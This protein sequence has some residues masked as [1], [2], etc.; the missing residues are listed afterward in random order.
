MDECYTSILL[1]TSLSLSGHCIFWKLSK[2]Q[3]FP[4]PARAVRVALF[5]PSQ[6]FEIT[7]IYLSK[8]KTF[9][10]KLFDPILLEY[11]Q[12]TKTRPKNKTFF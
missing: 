10:C 12:E 9:V 2:V 3:N 4:S 8:R 6:K 1:Y 5:K 7:A 11:Q